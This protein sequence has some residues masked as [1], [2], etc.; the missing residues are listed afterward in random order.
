MSVNII[1]S[2]KIFCPF[3]V[4]Q[5]EETLETFFFFGDIFEKQKV[6]LT[7]SS[8]YLITLSMTCQ[9]FQC[10]GTTSCTFFYYHHLLSATAYFLFPN[11]K[12][13]EI[14]LLRTNV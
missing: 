2:T 4:E 13:L 14:F 8:T 6:F 10:A 1:I 11:D 3:F 12:N 9:N 5:K 7:F